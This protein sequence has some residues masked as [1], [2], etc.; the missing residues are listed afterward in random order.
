LAVLAA[1][2]VERLILMVDQLEDLATNR[3][4]SAAKRS[5]EIGRIRDLLEQPPYATHLRM[6]FTFHNRAARVLERFWE[7]NRL[8]RFEVAPDNMAALVLLRGLHD[9]EKAAKLLAVYLEDSRTEEIEGEI[10]PFEMD[11]IRVLRVVAENRP[12]PFLAHASRLLE[13]AATENAPSITG[14]LAR[15]FFQGEI[16]LVG[17]DIEPDAADHDVDDVLLGR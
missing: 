3:A 16:E 4:V 2:D 17:V 5:K 15:S 13:Y 8:P 1:A 11:A 7:D 10:L 9:D 14:D 6:V 12:G